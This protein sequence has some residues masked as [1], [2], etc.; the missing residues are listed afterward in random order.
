LGY[1][2]T[3]NG[4][5]KF[6]HGAHGATEGNEYIDNKIFN[7]SYRISSV[8]VILPLPEKDVHRTG[9]GF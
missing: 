3:G 2:R 9:M 5:E 4:E 7:G 6:S 1:T 8:V